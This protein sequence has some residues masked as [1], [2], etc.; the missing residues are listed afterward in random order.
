MKNPIISIRNLSVEFN[1]IKVLDDIS[2][3]IYQDDVD[4]TNNHSKPKIGE[5][6]IGGTEK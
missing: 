3:D 5:G 1:S 4:Q 2:L 6:Q